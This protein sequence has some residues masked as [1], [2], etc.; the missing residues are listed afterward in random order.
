MQ[1]SL[2]ELTQPNVGGIYWV[3]NI[4]YLVPHTLTPMARAGA[5]HPY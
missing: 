2:I 4:A 5:N 1:R 3:S